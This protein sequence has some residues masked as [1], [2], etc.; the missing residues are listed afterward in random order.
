M[1]APY[2]EEFATFEEFIVAVAQAAH[3]N[4]QHRDPRL[5]WSSA[6]GSNEITPSEGGFLVQRDFTAELLAG[7]EAKSTVYP[8]TRRIPVGRGN[9]IHCP[10][11]DDRSRSINR[12]PGGTQM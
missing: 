9:A 10:M 8:L 12:G 11:F 2:R 5:F 6:L 1:T 7:V 4:G 3:S